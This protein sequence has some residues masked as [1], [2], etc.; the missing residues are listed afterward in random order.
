MKFLFNSVALIVFILANSACG[1]KPSKNSEQQVFSRL[2]YYQKD[3][4][5]LRIN[6]LLSQYKGSDHFVLIDYNTCAR[7]SED[8]INNFFETLTNTKNLSIIFSD[9]VIYNNYADSFPN[10][11]WEYLDNKYW[12]EK[13]IQSSVVLEYKRIN[14]DE[15][16]R[17]DS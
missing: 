8:K 7:C 12:K 6:N 1:E 4:F 11:K 17:V 16:V 5:N 10:V 13:G 14:K 3:T 9:S 15:F 2:D